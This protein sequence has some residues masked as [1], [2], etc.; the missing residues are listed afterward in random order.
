MVYRHGRLAGIAGI[1]FALVLVDRLVKAAPSGPPWQLVVLGAAVL[2]GATTWLLVQARRPAWLIALANAAVFAAA[3]VRFVAP[4]ATVA[5]LLPTSSGV[6]RTWTE[7]QRAVD[8]VHRGVEPVV[9]LPGLVV[10]LAALFWLAAALLVWGL[11]RG[12]PWVA[13]VPPLVLAAQ[14]A[15]IDRARTRWPMLL[16]FVLLLAGTLA[17][18]DADERGRGAGLMTRTRPDGAPGRR[19]PSV[20]TILLVGVAVALSVTTAASFRRLVPRDG[21]VPWRSPSGLAGGFFGSVAYNPF[22]EIHKGLVS[23]TGQVLFT[24]RIT[25]DVDP[26][27]VYFRLLTLETF[28]DG[29]WFADDPTI[30]PLDQHPWE[31]RGQAFAGPTGTVTAD[32]QIEAL[33]MDWLPAPYRPTSFESPDAALAENV[34]VRHRDAA[35]VFDGGRTSTGDRYRVTAEIPRLDLGVLSREPDGSLSPL[36]ATAAADEPAALPASAVAMP[37]PRELN[38]RRRFVELPPD[39][40]PR[41]GRKARELTAL[42]D[43]PFEKGLALEKWFRQSGGFVYDLDVPTGHDTATVAEWLFDDSPSN[44]G[45]R[46]GYCEQFATSMALMARTLD[47]PSRVVLGF[48]PGRQVGNRV[49]VLDNNAHS[50]VELWIPTQGWVRFDPTPR[51]DGANPITYAQLDDRLGFDVTAYLDQIPEPQRDPLPTAEA[52]NPVIDR[53]ADP[54]R[55]F[56]G[57]GTDEPAARNRSPLLPRLG[58]LLA[59]VLLLATV[60]GWKW[61]RRRRRLARLRAGDVAAAWEDIVERLDDLGDPPDETSTPMEVA[62]GLDGALVPLSQVYSDAVYGGIAVDDRRRRTALSSYRATMERLDRSYPRSRRILSWYRIRV[63]LRRLLRRE[64]RRSAGL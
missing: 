16:V 28:D 61:L 18:V 11:H 34:R 51:G 62:A 50:W 53:P 60:P 26:S 24:A 43:T 57:G 29:R 13:L 27:E 22:V 49:V 56:L 58:W 21:V 37:E 32:V 59:L 41:I 39:I 31:D 8:L 17:A 25:G 44:P 7:L 64:D 2:G 23:Q 46:R 4:E 52:N 48:T 63:P 3:S 54:Q 36:F 55:L 9:P 14:F 40:D 35:L 6:A 33:A 38:D 19:L 10:V 20:A 15:T 45:Y 30:F 42:L 12:H 47:I 1:G 5:F